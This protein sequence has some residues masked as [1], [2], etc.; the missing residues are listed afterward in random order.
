[1]E[2]E[3]R[4]KI[5]KLIPSYFISPQEE[6]YKIADQILSLIREAGYEP[7]ESVREMVEK[8]YADGVD[9]AEQKYKGYMSTEMVKGLV[10]E[11]QAKKCAQ[12]PKNQ[13]EQ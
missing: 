13:E 11:L 12:C 1:M 4:E 10:F 9:D 3:L 5:A 6:S 7:P 8:S 2:E